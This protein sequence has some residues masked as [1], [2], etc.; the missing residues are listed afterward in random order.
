ME[1]LDQLRRYQDLFSKIDLFRTEIEKRNQKLTAFESHV[2][3]MLTAKAPHEQRMEQGKGLSRKFEADI[4][5]LDSKIAK[6]QE[7][8]S[9]ATQASEYSGLRQQIEKY[10]ADKTA[11][12]E[13]LLTIFSKIEEIQ[14]GISDLDQKLSHAREEYL[15]LKTRV[16]EENQ[17]FEKEI[18]QMEAP[19][20]QARSE[21]DAELLEVFDRLQPSIGSNILVTA[22]GDCCGGC[23]VSLAPQLMERIRQQKEF[24]F[25]NFCGR[26]LGC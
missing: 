14:N 12:E 10:E 15:E 21:V 22:P 18:F 16:T 3:E 9:N 4:A 17:D 23:H 6:T 25:C 2:A 26:V 19:L 1:K 8:L 5:D 7:Q 20:E 11:L 24:V 13:N